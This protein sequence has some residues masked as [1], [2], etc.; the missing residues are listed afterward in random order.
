M[1]MSKVFFGN[2]GSDA[3]DT[4]VKLVWYYNN[5]L[6]RPAEEED[7]LAAA[8]LPR[9]DGGAGEADRAARAAPGFDLPL[10]M[11]RHVTAPHRLLGGQPG[12]SDEEFAARLADELEAADR[13]E[14]PDTIAAFIA[15]P[16]QG[17]GGV[18]VPPPDYFD[19]RSR[20]CCAPRHPAH[21][22]RGDHRLRPARPWFGAER[23]RD[24]AR[25]RHGREGHHVGYVPL[26]LPRLA[27][28][29]ERARRAQ[30]RRSAFAHGYTYSAHPLA[31]AAALANLDMIES[32][33]LVAQAAARGA[34]LHARL[35]EARATTRSSPR[36]AASG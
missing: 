3:N 17:A 9:R 1:P 30:R 19:A 16:V 13:A 7:H 4:Q 15:E 10:P 12:E 20:R 24:R 14:G 18:I 28:G 5:A 2:S 21:R 11:I 25:P 6:G 8:R 32:D 34:Y 33:D 23:L 36:C 31:A 29:L 22:R 35:R 26:R 27:R